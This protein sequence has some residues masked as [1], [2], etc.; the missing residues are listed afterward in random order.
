MSRGGGRGRGRAHEHGGQHRYV[1][2]AFSIP[3]IAASASTKK[4]VLTVRLI[5]TW[6]AGMHVPVCAGSAEAAPS[7]K[8][9]KTPVAKKRRTAAPTSGGRQVH[10][11]CPI[12]A[13]HRH[14]P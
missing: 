5:L 2:D 8:G 11:G 1:I 10:K 6:A 9:T 3:V 4:H 13:C 7:G 14:R 12:A